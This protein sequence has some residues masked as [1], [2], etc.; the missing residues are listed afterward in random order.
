MKTITGIFKNKLNDFVNTNFKSQTNAILFFQGFPLGFYQ[1]INQAQL[2]HFCNNNR[3]NYIDFRTI[4]PSTLLQGLL[5]AKGICWGYY[6]EFV[7]LSQVL[8]DF[9]VYQGQI[10]VINNN[11]FSDYYPIP[12]PI[13]PTE[14]LEL[15]ENETANMENNTIFKFYADVKM[16]GE[17]LYYSYVN[18]HFD[19]DINIKVVLPNFFRKQTENIEPPDDIEEESVNIQDIQNVKAKLLAGDLAPKLY[20]VQSLNNDILKDIEILNSIGTDLDI[21]FVLDNVSRTIQEKNSKKHLQI[22]KKYWGENSDFRDNAFYK[23]PAYSTEIV[24]LSQGTIITDLIDQCDLAINSTPTFY[25][26]I[27]VTAPTGAGKSLFF[28]VPGIYLHEQ[29]Q[30]L[31]IVICPLIALMNDQVKELHERGIEFATFINSEIIFEERQNRLNG[32]LSGRYS[33]LYVSPEF[34]LSHDIRSLVGDRKIGLLVIDEAHLVTS[35]GRDFRVDYWF[36]G[37]YLEKIRRGSYYS[38]NNGMNFPILC[39]TA[40]AVFGGRDDVIEDL[41]KSLH[42]VCPPE[43]LYLGH[44]CRDNIHFKINRHK[45]DKSTSMEKAS[46]TAERIKEFIKDK[47]KTIVYFPYI[48]QIEDVKNLLPGNDHIQKYSGGGMKSLEKDSSYNRF[49]N[50]ESLIMLATKAFGLG[51]NIPDVSNVYHYAPTGTLADYVQEIGRAARTLPNGYAIIDFYPNDMRFAR[52]LWGL[53]GLRHYQ[54]RAIIKKLYDLYQLKNTRNMLV[55]PDVFSYLFDANSIEMKVKSGLMLLASDLLEKYHF[56]VIAVR[57][58]NLFTYHYIVVPKNIESEFLGEYG[59]Y[60]KEMKDDRPRMQLSYGSRSDIK[61]INAGKIFEINLGE[62]WENKF[63]DYTFAKFKYRFFSGDLFTF[64]NETIVPRLKLTIDYD[65]GYVQ[66][67][68]GLLKI[69]S[70]VQKTFNEIQQKYGGKN[71]QFSE[72]SHIF[73]RY[74]DRIIKREYLLMLIDIFCYEKTDIYD[75]PN[76]QWKFIERR[77][78]SEKGNISDQAYCIRT[79]KYGFIETNIKRYLVQAV[80]NSGNNKKFVTYLPIPKKNG[81]YSEYQLVASLLELFDLAT[82]DLVGGRNPQIFVRI[83]DPLKLK[84]IAESEVAYRNGILTDIEARHTRAADIMNRFMMS[85]LDDSSRWRIIEN[86]FLGND[87]I[88]DSELGI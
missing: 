36:L 49:R 29:Y 42:L 20:K 69:I 57:P 33:I 32:I 10:Y 83:N 80:P 37:D 13:S 47:E 73:N 7:G 23:D 79:T 46:L 6:E 25:S 74:S 34:L 16:I 35:W 27:I 8:N 60:C 9:T 63:V 58:K 56:R 44:V 11:L 3:D 66:G 81:K 77:K 30:A 28:Q 76:E 50:S 55:S 67:R 39:L 88:V 24:K 64:P 14:A 31:T 75:I 1:A 78:G 18:K 82:Y 59:Y 62:V 87:G 41:Q 40:T 53:S 72:F 68:D 17:T 85:A 86:Y 38:K 52:T 45:T 51:V 65:Q 26:D 22:F 71:F 43:H 5:S 19:V 70:A 15:F 2:P 61:I 48:S 54:I 12:V 21:F 84:R 4:Q